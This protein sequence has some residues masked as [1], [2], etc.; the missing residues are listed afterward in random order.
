MHDASTIMREEHQNQQPT[1]AGTS[2]WHNEEDTPKLPETGLD[3]S[4][5]A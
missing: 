3:G 5:L 2:P 4:I 1:A